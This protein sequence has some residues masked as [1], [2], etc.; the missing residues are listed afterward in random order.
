MREQGLKRKF[1]GLRKWGKK[2]YIL[3]MLYDISRDS[4]GIP[5]SEWLYVSTRLVWAVEREVEREFLNAPYGPG[6]DIIAW[7]VR[8]GQVTVRAAG[9]TATAGKG[10]WIF[11]GNAAGRQAMQPGT[12]ILSLR[13]SAEWPTGKMLFDHDGA[14]IFEASTERRLTKTAGVLEKLAQRVSQ[15]KG[16]FL[17]DEQMASVKSYFAIRRAFEDWLSAYVDAML[18]T[19]RQPTATAAADARVLRVAQLMDDSPPSASP[20]ERELAGKAGLSVSQLNRLFQRDLGTSPKKYMERRRMQEA[21][22]LLRHHRRSVKETAYE[23]GFSSLP[24]F[25]AWFRRNQG[26]SPRDFLRRKE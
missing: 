20:S 23:L 7:L 6:H 10:E 26:V 18:R 4:P 13:F 5:I 17:L 16:L 24:H 21:V 2:L 25:S 22:L 19:G 12:V 3:R 1:A 15:H 9:R 8:R 14:I 11:P